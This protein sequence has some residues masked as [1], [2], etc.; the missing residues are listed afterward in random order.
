MM[1]VAEFGL[2]HSIG[3]RDLKRIATYGIGISVVAL[4]YISEVSDNGFWSLFLGWA[5]S[6]SVRPDV[7][8]RQRG[9]VLRPQ[10]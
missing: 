4:M 1:A 8:G 3:H 10:Q 5:P 9:T 2:A 6:A 7:R